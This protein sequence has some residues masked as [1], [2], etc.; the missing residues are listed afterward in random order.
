MPEHVSTVSGN[1]FSIPNNGSTVMDAVLASDADALGLGE[2]Q[3]LPE[4]GW[5]GQNYVAA[6]SVCI[7]ASS[8]RPC[9]SG[10][11]PRSARR[12]KTIWI[13]SARSAGCDS[14]LDGRQLGPPRGL[15]SEDSFHYLRVDRPPGGGELS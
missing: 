10:G 9:A 15:R 4:A 1:T 7:S 6:A 3:S 13:F 14:F 5:M 2:L 11:R 8:G 12:P